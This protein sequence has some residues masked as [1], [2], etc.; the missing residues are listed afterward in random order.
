MATIRSTGARKRR[1]SRAAGVGPGTVPGTAPG[2]EPGTAPGTTPG[3]LEPLRLHLGSRVDVHH[4]QLAVAGVGEG[5]GRAGGRDHDRAG[6]GDHL[7]AAYA[8][9]CLA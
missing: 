5:M 8:D 2:T 7:V 9:R 4:P 6:A 1:D 3:L